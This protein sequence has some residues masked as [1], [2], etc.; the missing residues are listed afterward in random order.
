[1]VLH[2]LAKSATEERERELIQF[3]NLSGREIIE[4]I[5]IIQEKQLL[6]LF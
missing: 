2:A 4:S 3:P 1:L 6:P 5:A